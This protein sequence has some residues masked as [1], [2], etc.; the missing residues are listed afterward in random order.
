MTVASARSDHTAQQA[1]R[2]FLTAA[3]LLSEQLG[4]ELRRESGMSQIHYELLA[5]L[6]E[7]PGRRLKMTG[8]ARRTGVSPSRLSHLVDRLE[9]RGWVG[10]LPDPADRRV[11]LA[12]LTDAGQRALT[13]AAPWHDACAQARLLDHL[14][15]EQLDHLKGISE[16]LLR[17]LS[18]Q[19][20]AAVDAPV[21]PPVHGDP[22]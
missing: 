1:M 3:R 5:H 13:E 10:R 21:P 22:R 2:A 6:A 8:L 17:R 14:T 20:A 15:D 16:V 7:S 19:A 18:G 11:H 9:Q 12:Q 4:Q